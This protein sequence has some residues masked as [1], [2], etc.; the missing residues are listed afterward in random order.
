M[1]TTYSFDVFLYQQSCLF[2]QE[3]PNSADSP[4]RSSHKNNGPLRAHLVHFYSLSWTIPYSFILSDA[5]RMQLFFFLF[6]GVIWISKT[7]R[8]PNRLVCGEPTVQSSSNQWTATMKLASQRVPWYLPSVG[9][10]LWSASWSSPP[11]WTTNIHDSPVLLIALADFGFDPSSSLLLWTQEYKNTPFFAFPWCRMLVACQT[12]TRHHFSFF[13]SHNSPLSG[14]FFCG[15]G[16]VRFGG[17][18]PAEEDQRAWDW[19]W[20]G[21]WCCLTV[22]NQAP[23][24]ADLG[25]FSCAASPLSTRWKERA[26]E[27]L[28]FQSCLCVWW[29]QVTLLLS[30][31]C[32]IFLTMGSCWTRYICIYIFVLHFHVSL[33]L[34]VLN[35]SYNEVTNHFFFFFS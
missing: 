9:P 14:K 26:E 12:C 23:N 15:I 17:G 30:A 28:R 8:W 32:N 11:D 16:P 19:H 35:L 29:A 27:D 7:I 22:I 5:A 33:P 21:G 3:C 10:R 18:S 31:R 1:N 6:A 34:I 20:I 24:H 4:A 13:M 25:I 2:R